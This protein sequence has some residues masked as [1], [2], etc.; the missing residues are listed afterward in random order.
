V[1][2]QAIEK[3]F[4]DTVPYSETEAGKKEILNL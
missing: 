4:Q 1:D 2:Y 3:I